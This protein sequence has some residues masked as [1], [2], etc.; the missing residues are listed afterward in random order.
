MN[1]GNVNDCYGCGI[2]SISCAAGAI[3]ITLNKN[4]FYE[5][6]LDKNKCVECGLCVRVCAYLDDKPVSNDSALQSYAAWSNNALVRRICSSGGIG[7][8]IGQQL[9]AKGYK[10]CGV[11]YNA[12]KTHAEHYVAGTREEFI[13]SIGSKY[14]QSYTVDGFKSINRKDKYLITGTPCQIDSFRRYIKLK[15]L[16]GNF[17]LLDFFCHGVPS[18]LL[19]E[20][21]IREV[22][23]ITGQVTYASWR[24]KQTGWHDSWAMGGV[25]G[26]QQGESV[27]WHD[28]YNLLIRGGGTVYNSRLSQG[29]LFYEMFLSD[30]CLGRACYFKC[31][32]KCDKSAADLRIGDL[33]GS[34]Y[35]ANE[36]GVSALISMTSKGQRII[37]EISNCTIVEE[38]FYTVAEGQMKKPPRY[39]IFYRLNI[40][41][42]KSQ[43]PLKSILWMHSVARRINRKI[44][45]WIK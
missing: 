21:Y 32:Y 11:R 7:F 34:K 23:K 15:K 39:P 25:D 8:E 9:I 10:V 29:D 40:S 36:D 4:G 38:S 16:E 31:K 3:K 14:I 45:S 43:V 35:K 13:P 27:N 30:A 18:M 44:H 19:W 22:E 2:C 5:P 17:V 24:N 12:E 28:S 26:T 20:K 33:W 41:L 6:R 1:I 37:N 42:L